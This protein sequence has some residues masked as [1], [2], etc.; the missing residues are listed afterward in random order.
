M[1]VASTTTV[2]IVN[3]KLVYFSKPTEKMRNQGVKTMML[4]HHTGVTPTP[5]MQGHLV[6][7]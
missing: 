1:D 6:G 2:I 4:S 5:I 3:L 7:R